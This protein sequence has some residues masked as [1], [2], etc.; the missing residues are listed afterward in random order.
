MEG[1]AMEWIDRLAEALGEEAPDGAQTAALLSA[2]RDVAHRVERK[3][4]P[5]AAYLLGA[6]AGRR[7]AGGSSSA[8]ALDDVLA[9]L[10]GVL[11]PEA[12]DG[13]EP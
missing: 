3:A 12:D 5:L 9:A 11:P 2:S 1:S 10:A 7:I 6:A 4:T 8:A 13:P